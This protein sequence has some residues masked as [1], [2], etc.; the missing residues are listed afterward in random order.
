MCDAS[1]D[2][3]VG[4][5]EQR[6][7][8]GEAERLGRLEIDDQLELNRALHGKIARLFAFQD[9]I[10]I[11]RRAPKIIGPILSV[12][13]QPTKFSEKTLSIKRQGDDSEPP[14]M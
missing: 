1:L 9:A 6:R 8:H 3:L 2:Y 7:R 10:R 13:Q 14:T 12:G 11:G 4:A 5:R